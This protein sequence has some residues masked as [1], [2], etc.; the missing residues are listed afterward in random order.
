ME[1]FFN[2]LN[3]LPFWFPR[4]LL[5][6][7]LLILALWIGKEFNNFSNK[8]T[9]RCKGFRV[10][11]LPIV[12]VWWVS[13]FII[14][15]WIWT[16]NPSKEITYTPGK[17]TTTYS[18]NSSI[19]HPCSIEPEKDNCVNK[20]TTFNRREGEYEERSSVKSNDLPKQTQKKKLLD[21]YS[22]EHD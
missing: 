18:F 15:G 7:A 14:V 10:S 8:S 19:P 5:I 22:G 17:G 13:V 12:V 11:N 1:N 21:E 2:L 9:I 6:L 4:F 16:T 3:C 20:K